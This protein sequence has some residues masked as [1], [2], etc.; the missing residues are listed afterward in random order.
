MEK[1]LGVAWDEEQENYRKEFGRRGIVIN[2]VPPKDRAMWDAPL[3]GVQDIWIQD[4]EKK[5]LPGKRSLTIS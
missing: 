5:G 2:P 4:M 1:I 3:K